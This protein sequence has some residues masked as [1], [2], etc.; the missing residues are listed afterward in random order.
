M[1]SGV[2]FCAIVFAKAMYWM[3]VRREEASLCSPTRILWFC[4]AL[5][6]A[7]LPLCQ[8]CTPWQRKNRNVRSGGSTGRAIGPIIHLQKS[9]AHY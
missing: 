3:S 8:C 2:R 7:Q 6:W 1:G 4:S 5:G 9:R